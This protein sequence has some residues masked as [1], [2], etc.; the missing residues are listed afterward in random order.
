MIEMK[1]SIYEIERKYLIRY[2]DLKL[3]NS[4]AD[5]TEITQT[6]LRTRNGRTTRGRKRGMDGA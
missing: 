6:Y 5:K 1:D 2:P 4:R 3:L